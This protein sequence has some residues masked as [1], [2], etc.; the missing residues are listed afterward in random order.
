MIMSYIPHSISAHLHTLVRG[1]PKS[2][3]NIPESFGSLRDF[4]DGSLGHSVLVS[5]AARKADGSMPLILCVQN[6]FT[7]AL[8]K[9]E[10]RDYLI[11]PVRLTEPVYFRT[12]L[13][14]KQLNIPKTAISDEWIPSIPLC[15]F[16]DYS[17][18]ILL[19]FN[20]QR[21]GTAEEPFL[22]RSE[23]ASANCVKHEVIRKDRL[24]MAE[25][26][27]ENMEN[28]IVHNPYSQE[29]REMAAIRDGDVKA[30]REAIEEDFTGQYGKLSKDNL[31]Q[32]KDMGIV[33]ITLASR[34]AI[35]GG[36]HP[37]TA[38]TMIFI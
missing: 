7:Y 17:E 29:L 12:T 2:G 4:S 21:A 22:R 38:F 26:I 30:L 23:L 14:L 10:L 11:G 35:E 33:T 32:E 20:C 3:K 25:Q 28:N 31:R 8:V 19:L 9:H 27:L 36:L 24:K 1:Y 37:E 34:A 15:S 5:N 13:T 6:V 18:E 16:D